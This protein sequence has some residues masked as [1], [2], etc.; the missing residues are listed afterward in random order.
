MTWSPGKKA[1]GLLE[2]TVFHWGGDLRQKGGES[3]KGMGKKKKGGS[4]NQKQTFVL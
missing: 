3:R 4:A 2:G 1:T